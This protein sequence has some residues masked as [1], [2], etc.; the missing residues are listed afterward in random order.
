[1]K[2][3]ALMWPTVPYHQNAAYYYAW[4]LMPA[5]PAEQPAGSAGADKK[6][7]GDAEAMRKWVAENRLALKRFEK[8]M[9]FYL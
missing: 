6:Y 9:I 2:I 4:A 7:E 5:P 1:M 3:L 8:R